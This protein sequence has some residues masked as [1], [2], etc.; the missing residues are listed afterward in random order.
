M[1]ELPTRDEFAACL[2]SRF[3]VLADTGEFEL[4][5]VE[6]SAEIESPY[7]RTFSLFLRGPLE[8][9]LPQQI[10]PLRH[11]RLG[12]LDLFLV[13]VERLVDWFRYQAV[14][15]QLIPPAMPPQAG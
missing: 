10:V 11:A 6:V 15:N 2:K 3:S 7:Q 12:R 1:P 4:E 9:F 13:P 14:F 5:L 8:P